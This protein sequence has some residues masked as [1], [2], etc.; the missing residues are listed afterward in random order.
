MIEKTLTKEK[1]Y[2]PTHE[3]ARLTTP[4]PKMTSEQDKRRSSRQPATST[5]PVRQCRHCHGSCLPSEFLTVVPS[6]STDL[7]CSGTIQ[8]NLNRSPSFHYNYMRPACRSQLRALEIVHPPLVGEKNKA[9]LGGMIA[10]KK[11]K[12]VAAIPHDCQ[13]HPLKLI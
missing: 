2:N 3:S 1:N 11:I 10:T 4:S 7:G 9:A 5:A 12:R 6:M 13:L 8:K